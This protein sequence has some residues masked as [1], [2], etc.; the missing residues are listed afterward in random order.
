[1]ELVAVLTLREFNL[2]FRGA[3]LGQLW[4][5]AQPVVNVFLY[6]FIFAGVMKMRLPGSDSSLAYALYI[7]A[8][9]FLWTLLTEVI[10][11]GKTLLTDHAEL[12]K[13]T[14]V[15]LLLLIVPVLLIALLNLAI[16]LVTLQLVMFFMQGWILPLWDILPPLLVLVFLCSGIALLLAQLYVF[17][18]DVAPL[19]D[20]ALQLGFWATPI[21]YQVQ[22]LPPW[23]QSAMHYHP[24]VPLFAL[25]QAAF[26]GAPL[27]MRSSL[28]YPLGVGLAIWLVTLVL[29]RR[30][31]ITLLDEL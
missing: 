20:I 28:L 6:T 29:Y 7:C 17:M 1:M 9:I 10:G 19:T 18:R 22:H 26:L 23:L 31:R 15:S 27:P 5:L 24:L 11:R 12:I 21:I 4:W 2:R 30:L 8:G 16:L 14:P 13:K 25:V 3:W